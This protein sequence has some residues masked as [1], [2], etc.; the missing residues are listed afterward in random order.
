MSRR[1]K[2]DEVGKEYLIAKNRP[3]ASSSDGERK[4]DCIDSP[5]I[6]QVVSQKNN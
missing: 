2:N 5:G 4:G 1:E 6:S 3:A